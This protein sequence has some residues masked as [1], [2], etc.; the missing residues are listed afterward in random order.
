ML[1][2]YIYIYDIS[3]LRV[4]DVP[5]IQKCIG[6]EETRYQRHI[7]DLCGPYKM[8]ELSRLAQVVFLFRIRKFSDLNLSRSI[9]YRD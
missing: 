8:E 5:V 1:H 7:R 3:C 6:Y 2:I 9:D 4:K